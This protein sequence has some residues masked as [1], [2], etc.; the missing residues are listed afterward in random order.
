MIQEIT[1]NVYLF[2]LKEFGS[3]V[4]FIKDKK[5]LID[6]ST[7]ANRDELIANLI[8]IGFKV[9]DIKFVINT[10]EHYDHISNNSEFKKAK[11]YFPK[12]GKNSLDMF[13]E[14]TKTRF[15]EDELDYFDIDVFYAEGDDVLGFSVIETPGHSIGSVCLFDKESGI[16]FSGD[17]VFSDGVFG[18]YDLPT[19]SKNALISSIEKLLNLDVKIVLPGHGKISHTPKED[20]VKCLTFLRT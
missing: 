5:A 4:Y 13:N 2:K 18:R 8:E 17:T 16:L 1:D 14:F 20:F 10:H 15:G 7:K 19:S 9:S 12:T 3:S 11:I 6:T